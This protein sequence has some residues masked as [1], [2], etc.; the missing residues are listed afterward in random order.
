M[1]NEN[2]RELPEVRIQQLERQLHEH[3]EALSYYQRVAAETAA[4]SIRHGSD[5]VTMLKERDQ[6]VAAIGC[7]LTEKQ[8]LIESLEERTRELL[9]VTESLRA[10]EARTGAII[11]YAAEGIV[12]VD[13]NG[14]IE[15]FNPAAG[16]IFDCD[17]QQMTGQSIQPL[18]DSKF[19]LDEPDGPCSGRDDSAEREPIREIVGHRTSGEL[20]PLELAVSTVEI[21]SR[22]LHTAMLR[23]LSK[24]KELEAERRRVNETLVEASRQAGKAEVATAVLHNVGNALNGVNTSATLIATLLEN[25]KLSGLARLSSLLDA[26]A[27][28]LGRYFEE[29]PTGKLIPAYL[30]EL[31]RVLGTEQNELAME[32]GSLLFGLEHIKAVVKTQQAF[33]RTT[34]DVRREVSIK[35]LVEDAVQVAQGPRWHSGIRLVREYLAPVRLTTDRHKAILIL[36][37]LLSNA[38]D[39]VLALPNNT[40]QI[41]LHVA[42]ENDDAVLVSVIDNGIGIA[43]ENLERIFSYAFTTKPDGHGFGLHSCAT[44][45]RELGGSLAARSAG[46]GLGSTFTLTL[47][48]RERDGTRERPNDD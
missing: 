5:L 32:L 26:H 28:D 3:T 47:P 15:M 17:A 20:F 40:P 2:A 48:L 36:V 38:V 42:A 35:D 30:S 16:R 25:S 24:Q 29:D 22:R 27:S 44:A 45:A 33:A 37:N 21:G 8:S 23:D 12:T 7:L 10:S 34:L 18:I 9:L 4:R 19:V 11:Q 6:A 14:R 1:A 43:E 31:S 39:A 13:D 41:T 46:P